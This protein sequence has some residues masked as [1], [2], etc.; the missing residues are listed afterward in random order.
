MHPSKLILWIVAIGTAIIGI[1]SLSIVWAV[2][3][4]II[5]Y[6]N[7]PDV[8]NNWGGLIVGFFLGNFFNFARS[9]LGYTNALSKPA[10]PTASLGE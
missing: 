5:E 3:Y 2:I 10:P 7:S 4:E 1:I 6:G 9:A 8:L